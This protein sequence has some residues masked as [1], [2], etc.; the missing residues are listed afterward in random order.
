VDPEA[1]A[2]RS[3][4]DLELAPRDGA[5]RCGSAGTRRFCG[6]STADADDVDL[7]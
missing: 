2:H 3:I 6:R 4:A 7:P 5:V 1:A